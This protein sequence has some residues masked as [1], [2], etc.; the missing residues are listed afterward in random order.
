MV[1]Q[2]VGSSDKLLGP[3]CALGV[4]PPGPL[5]VLRLSRP[6]V[7]EQRYPVALVVF[8]GPQPAIRQPVIDRYS[9][10]VF[11]WIR[12]T[13]IDDHRQTKVMP[14]LPRPATQQIAAQ[15][16]IVDPLHDD[17][18]RG[19]LDCQ[20]RFNRLVETIIHAIAH[21]FTIGIVRFYRIINQQGSVPTRL[22]VPS[23]KP[24]DLTSSRRGVHP[25]ALFGPPH[26]LAVCVVLERH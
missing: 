26:G 22:H 24:C 7:R 3:Q 12:Q 4:E 11:L 21:R 8:I 18:H 1:L 5:H 23:T 13:I 19:R 16:V 15:V 10:R 9:V 14:L 25:A 2:Q 20:A 17:D 6:A